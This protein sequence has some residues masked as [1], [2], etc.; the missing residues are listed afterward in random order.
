MNRS[1]K[2]IV[3]EAKSKRNLKLALKLGQVPD[4]LAE[5]LSNQAN[6]DIRGYE[7]SI[8]NFAI[9]HVLKNH[10]NPEVES[11]RGQVAVTDKDFELIPL[12]L[13][14]PDLVFYEGKSRLD[15]DVFQFQK[16]IGNNYIVLKEVRTGKR[17]LALLSMRI[18]KSK[19]RK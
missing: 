14:N 19:N 7:F 13:S 1:I 17:E 11:L 8:D 15:K 3:A 16:K 18:I 10:G 9:K 4:E 2:E 5:I 12:V 6:F